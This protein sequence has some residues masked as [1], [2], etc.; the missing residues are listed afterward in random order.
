MITDQVM[1]RFCIVATADLVKDMDTIDIS[2]ID[3]GL[4]FQ[5]FPE[6]RLGVRRR[7]G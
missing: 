1:I 3:R 2:L 6:A 5:R 4:L 7:F